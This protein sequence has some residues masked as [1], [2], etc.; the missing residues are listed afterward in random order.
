[1]INCINIYD[2]RNVVDRYKYWEHDAILADLDQLRN[3][4]SVICSNIVG[5]FNIGTVI[6]NANAFLASEVIIYGNKRYDRRGTVG[7]H[8]YT[9]FKHVRVGE[10][11]D[12]KKLKEQGCVLIGID[13]IDNAKSIETYEWPVQSHIVMIFGEE[14]CGISG[15]IRDMCD[16]FLYISQYGSVRS[17][18]VGTASGIA[19]YELCKRIKSRK[20]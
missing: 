15:P 10:E 18:N 6:R 5:D 14:S 4:F 1:M 12:I 11:D 20:S 9:N 7:T 2:K 16:D 13:N 17:L 19:M 3:N 8:L